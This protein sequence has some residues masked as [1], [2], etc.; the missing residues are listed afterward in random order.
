MSVRVA[1][2]P[3]LNWSVISS[4]IRTLTSGHIPEGFKDTYD[5]RIWIN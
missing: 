1:E 4:N 2:T 5:K 3:R